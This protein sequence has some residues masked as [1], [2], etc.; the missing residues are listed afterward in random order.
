MKI[1]RLNDLLFIATGLGSA[2][3]RIEG[4]FTVVDLQE[5]TSCQ[6][7]GGLPSVSKRAPKTAG[8]PAEVCLPSVG[9]FSPSPHP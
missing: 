7:D 1:M 9:G 2:S 4:G 5:V 6:N 3:L 8:Q